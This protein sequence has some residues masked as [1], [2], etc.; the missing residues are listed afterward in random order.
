MRKVF[1]GAEK[2]F[3]LSSPVRKHIEESGGAYSLQGTQI[4]PPGVDVDLFQS[5]HEEH[6]D[7]IG[8]KYFVTVGEVKARKGHD[9]SLKAF[10]LISKEF[11][12]LHYVI[13]GD[14]DASHVFYAELVQIINQYSLQERVIF[15]GKVDDSELKKV[16]S[17]ADFFVMTSRTTNEFIEGFGIVYL[18]A[19]LYGLPSIGAKKTGAEDAIRHGETGFIVELD[20]DVVAEAMRKCMYDAELRNALGK[21]AIE[22]ARNFSWSNVV[23]IYKDAFR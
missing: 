17:H 14:Y 23:D 2:I 19:G 16:Y 20:A 3:V 1:D 11:P 21:K 15:L 5:T 7:L 18:E 8:K 10:A 13:V 6:P 12:E 9:I 22:H 4:I